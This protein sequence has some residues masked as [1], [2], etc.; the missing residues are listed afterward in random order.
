MI[1]WSCLDVTLHLAT[2]IT[3]PP[4]SGVFQRRGSNSPGDEDY[5]ILAEK[6]SPGM[7]D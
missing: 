5:S 4:N 3:K 1:E 7:D 6:E 2:A